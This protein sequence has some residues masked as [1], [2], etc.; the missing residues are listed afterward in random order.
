METINA[1]PRRKFRYSCTQKKT[2][3]CRAR[4]L[5]PLSTAYGESPLCSCGEGR[6]LKGYFD[7]EKYQKLAKYATR[8]AIPLIFAVPYGL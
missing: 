7:G 1:L 2:C 8:I 5:F 4:N 3:E 6:E